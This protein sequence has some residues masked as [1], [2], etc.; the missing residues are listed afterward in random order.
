MQNQ[1]TSLAGYAPD[2]AS[3]I[4]IRMKVLAGEIYSIGSAVDWL[5]MQTFA[6]SAQGEQ[7]ELRAQE[8]G[9]TR[10]QAVA[11]SG[12][13]TFRRITPLWY[14]ALIPAGTVCATSGDQPVRYITTEDAILKNGELSIEVS[15]RA[16][17]GGKIGNTQ[18]GTVTVMVTPPA[19]LESVTNTSAFTGGEDSESDS[20]LRS[21]LMQS[22]ASISNGTNA[23]FYRE[24]ALK[25]DGV[26][27]VGVV[28]RENGAGTVGLYL[29]GRGTVPLQE[30]IDKVQSG[31]NLLREVNVDVKV[32]AAQTVAVDVDIAVTPVDTVSVQDAQA[33]C[34][35]AVREYFDELSVGEPVIVTALGVK[36]FATGKIK[37][38]LFNAS[39]TADRKLG[40]NQLA[41]CGSVKV[42]Y[43]A[44]V[45]Q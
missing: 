29:G 14:D 24:C 12:M 10:K 32:A 21:R 31:L 43:Y 41:V 23:A 25:Y 40:M 3:D 37:N 17:Q 30:V 36:V 18:P 28:P 2:D 44:G 34:E 15:A 16:E 35:Q 45:E 13:L 4:G 9:L 22:Y 27:S 42:G 33:A 11:S 38:Y 7:L 8:R 6:Q 19:A 20:E 26:Y 1:F 5:K 39:A